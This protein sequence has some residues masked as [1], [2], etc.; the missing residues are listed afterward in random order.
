[1]RVG[2]HGGRYTWVSQGCGCLSASDAAQGVLRSFTVTLA[3]GVSPRVDAIEASQASSH[4]PRRASA[5]SASRLR[6]GR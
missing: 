6:F 2:W 3:S 5:G 1:M 4:R